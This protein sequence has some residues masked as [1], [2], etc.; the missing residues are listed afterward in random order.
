MASFFFRAARHVAMAAVAVAM[1]SF[2]PHAMAQ[3]NGAAPM[4]YY[5]IMLNALRTNPNL[6]SDAIWNKLSEEQILAAQSHYF[7]RAPSRGMEPIFTAAQVKDR[8]PGMASAEL[9]PVLKA[10]IATRIKVAPDTLVAKFTLLELS[11]D[12]KTG[13]LVSK[14]CY[15][16]PRERPG[17]FDLLMPAIELAYGVPS[18][19]PA[20]YQPSSG[21]PQKARSMAVYKIKENLAADDSGPVLALAS[22]ISSGARFGFRPEEINLALDRWVEIDGVPLARR[23]AELLLNEV[24]RRKGSVETRVAFT[25]TGAENGPHRAA[26]YGKLVSVSILGPDGATIASFPAEAFPAVRVGAPA[27]APTKEKTAATAPKTTPLPA[28]P[29]LDVIGLRLGMPVAAADKAI[30]AH[31]TVGWIYSR[32]RTGT[33]AA[34]PYQPMKAYIAADLSEVV[35]AYF[36]PSTTGGTIVAVRRRS[37]IGQNVP[38]ETLDAALRQKYGDAAVARN[39][40]WVW[41]KPGGCSASGTGIISPDD[42]KLIE[43]K[44]RSDRAFLDVVASALDL[45]TYETVT[46]K[47]YAS[48][49]PVLHVLRDKKG[50]TTT[51]VDQRLAM[52]RLPA[53]NSGA[54]TEIKF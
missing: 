3:S 21:L 11:Y 28:T 7:S 1:I 5:L 27:M 36:E 8:N 14:C 23:A 33:A 25:V 4:S 44:A 46:P 29:E 50:V 40:N 51:L 53:K 30:G 19:T 15:S 20:A 31:M 13:K 9:A 45:A 26:L 18:N 2:T 49:G 42:L 22:L 34:T 52:D 41:G 37:M 43:G 48:C 17:L 24:A 39:D 12:D 38:A 54:E 10:D 6:L 32:E 16:R 35:L 47:R